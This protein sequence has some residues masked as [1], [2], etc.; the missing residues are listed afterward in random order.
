MSIEY[1]DEL[2]HNGSVVNVFEK[3]SRIKKLLTAHLGSLEEA[4][5]L[6]LVRGAA[7][8]HYKMKET[9]NKEEAKV[10]EL[11]LNEDYNPDTVYKWLLLS[12]SA[13]DLKNRLRMRLISQKKAF[14]EKK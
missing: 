5:L 3:V 8:W 14:S 9:I 1:K 6:E 11:L 13:H 7:K 12:R 4:Q 2:V 10:Y